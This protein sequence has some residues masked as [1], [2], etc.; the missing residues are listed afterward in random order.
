MPDKDTERIKYETE[1]LKLM[2]LFILAIGGSAI[3]LLLGE[4]TATRLFLTVLGSVGSVV[5]ILGVEA[6]SNHQEAAGRIEGGRIM[7]T[8]EWVGLACALVVYTS[9]VVLFWKM[10]SH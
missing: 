3:G 8:Y 7:T 5:L 2:A 1:L 10:S 4:R 6:T 9:I